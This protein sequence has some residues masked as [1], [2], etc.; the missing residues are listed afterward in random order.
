M[1]IMTYDGIQVRFDDRTLAHLQV[2]V[3]KKF[4]NQESFIVSWRNTDTSGDGRSTVWMTPS[5]PAHFHIEKPAHKLDPEWL[6][7]LQRSADSAAGLVVR[8][9]GGEVVL[10]EQMSPQL[11]KG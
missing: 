4:R 2:I 7:A 6:T 10:G 1:G 3:L 5:F 11:P 9:A 8:D